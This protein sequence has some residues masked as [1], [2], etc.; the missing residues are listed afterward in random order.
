MSVA[1]NCP[2][3]KTLRVA[4]AC[5]GRRMKCPGCGA[6]R[7]VEAPPAASPDTF[8]D[9][10]VV[11]DEPATPAAKAPAKKA[12]VKAVAVEEEAAPKPALA[13]KPETAPEPAN[14]F[15]NLGKKKKKKKKK[16]KAEAGTDGDDDWYEKAL[17]N[18]RWLKRVVRGVAYLVLGII[19]LI[20]FGIICSTRWQE[21]KDAAFWI[22][23][24]VL[25]VPV[26]GVIAVV[27]GVI[28]LAFGQFLGDDE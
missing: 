6:V 7:L 19:I 14:P 12:A 11:E 26:A 21:V 25:I 17:E 24:M 1:F 27:K 22:Q 18:E 8:D 13:A 28:G 9:F 10:E 5:V 4:D 23:G 3:G 20:G 2:C 15:T 16:K